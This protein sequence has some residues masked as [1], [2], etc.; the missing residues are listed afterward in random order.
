[1]PL[2]MQVGLE[3]GNFML[4]RETA[5]RPKKGSE[6]PIL[7]PCLL[8][9]NGWMDQDE[10]WYAGGSRSRPHCARWG[11]SSPP[12]K[13]GRV[14]NFRSISIVAKRLDTSRC[15]LVHRYA[16]AQAT[17]CE[18]GTQ[19]PPKRAQPPIFGPCLLWSNGCVYQYTT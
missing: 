2:G 4:G 3:T 13:E 11:P 19:P 15:H 7:G 12:Q 18:T 16:S 8:W 1:M 9:P 6:P 14:P 10:T 17:L 5:P